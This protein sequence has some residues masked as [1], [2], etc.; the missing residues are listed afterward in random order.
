MSTIKKQF[1]IFSHH[2]KLVYLDSASTSQKPRAVIDRI[3]RYYETENAN[4]H[5][6]IYEL[7]EKATQ[8]Y[9]AVREKVA[10][11]INAKDSKEIV[12]VRGATEGINIVA[13]G[14]DFTEDDEI[15]I[16]E[17]EHHSNIV[18]WQRVNSKPQTLNSNTH[19]K[20]R[21]VAFIPITKDGKLELSVL[22][23]LVTNKTKIVAI[24]YVS[25]VLGTIN[26]IKEIVQ[27]VKRINPKCLVLV[28]AAQAV[29]HMHVDVQD[30]GCDFLVFSGHKM[31][32]PTGIGVLWGKYELLE[33]LR[34]YQYGSSMIARVGKTETTF[35]EIPYKFEAGTPHI[36]GVIGLGAAIDFLEEIGLDAIFAHDK[37]LTE[38]A[39]SRL[40]EIKDVS[41]YG[42]RD[43]KVHSSVIAFNIGD[44]H[45]HDVAQVLDE[46]HV[47]VRAGHHCAMPLHDA[48]GVSA[49]VRA[50]FYVYNTNADIDA[51]VHG[52]ERVK[53]I[54]ATK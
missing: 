16:T 43:P 22:P 27:E 7:S 38:Y 9:E 26:P 47:A 13:Q 42:S 8:A 20:N 17:M 35:A 19:V 11:L 24:A 12:F 32:A 14:L 48:L 28:D 52:I 40:Q 18:P 51:L 37:T 54:F 1:P 15:V 31:C 33:E 45:A 49:T 29:P 39:L 46:E 44:I 36:A 23:R 53:K 3:V 6:G 2:P 4:V 41:L 5:R 30:L 25:N 34:P 10:R 50:S 21:S